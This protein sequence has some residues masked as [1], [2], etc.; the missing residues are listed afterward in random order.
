MMKINVYDFDKT[1]YPGD[2]T[3]EFYFFCLK[4]QPTLLRF[5]PKQLWAAVQYKLGG[6]QKTAF[7]QGFFSFLRGVSAVEE[8]VVEFWKKRILRLRPLMMKYPCE[9]NLI[10]TAS[11]EFL[12]KVVADELDAILI[13]SQVDP[14]TGEFTCE[15]CYGEEKVCRFRKMLPK[16]NID[17]F[18]S[19]SVSDQPLAQLA[20]K[21]YLVKGKKI[22]P[23]PE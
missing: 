11:P 12:V 20:E 3:V 6:I 4:R 13:G 22:L 9:T 5:L 14:T 10:I 23:W 15:N 18:F 1:L 19:D 16:Y 2:S 21:A 17:C 8:Q 7:K